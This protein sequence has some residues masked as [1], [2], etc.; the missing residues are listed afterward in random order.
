MTL[1]TFS[2]VPCK[3]GQCCLPP[4][5][6]SPGKLTADWS[7]R[8]PGTIKHN[9]ISM[10]AAAVRITKG[11]SCMYFKVKEISNS[12]PLAEKGQD[13]FLKLI[14]MSKILPHT[15]LGMQTLAPGIKV[16]Y[17]HHVNPTQQ[18]PFNLRAAPNCSSSFTS[19]GITHRTPLHNW[20]NILQEASP[21]ISDAEIHSTS[22]DWTVL[23]AIKGPVQPVLEQQGQDPSLAYHHSA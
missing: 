2:L 5:Q 13:V 8:L 17:A 22:P 23:C 16:L 7:G 21:G 15:L 1:S 18:P 3:L 11:S 9:V 19:T 12:W 6:K 14:L 20:W 4:A 10:S